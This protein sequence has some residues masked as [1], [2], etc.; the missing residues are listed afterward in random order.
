MQLLGVQMALAQG[1]GCAEVF[2]LYQRSL[3]AAAAAKSG[4]RNNAE[5]RAL[6]EL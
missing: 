6:W 5:F 3:E 1:N 4:Q 2:N